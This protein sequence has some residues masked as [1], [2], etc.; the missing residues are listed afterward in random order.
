MNTIQNPNYWFTVVD[1]VEYH[2]HPCLFCTEKHSIVVDHVHYTSDGTAGKAIHHDPFN[3]GMGMSVHN[4]VRCPI[5]KG[6]GY[7]WFTNEEIAL[8]P[9]FFYKLEAALKEESN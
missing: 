9:L 7:K 3:Y 8:N 6:E 2:K 5:C 1:G 4:Y